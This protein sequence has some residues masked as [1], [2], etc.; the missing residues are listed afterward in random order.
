MAYAVAAYLHFVAIFLLF[1]LLVLEH[2][3]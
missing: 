2:Q 1:S 3:L